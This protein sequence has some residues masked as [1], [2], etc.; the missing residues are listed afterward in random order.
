MSVDVGMDVHRQRSPVA[1]VDEAGAPS[2]TATSPTI[3]PS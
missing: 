2:A 1:I 3:R